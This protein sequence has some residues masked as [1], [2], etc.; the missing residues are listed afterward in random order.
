MRHS[1]ASAAHDNG[2]M[3]VLGRATALIQINGAFTLRTTCTLVLP[4]CEW[5]FVW[6][7]DSW[8]SSWGNRALR[9]HA[10]ELGS[11][12][13]DDR[14]K[15]RPNLTHAIEDCNQG[16][17]GRGNSAGSDQ[18]TSPGWVPAVERI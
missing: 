13:D 2:L 4:G 17:L 14:F 8:N 5:R 7:V 18:H 15:S 12:P 10:S 1:A 3:L 11:I 16:A 9:S 6:R